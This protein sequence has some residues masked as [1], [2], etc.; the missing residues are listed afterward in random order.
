MQNPSLYNVIELMARESLH[1]CVQIWG[2][3]GTEQ[4]IKEL[5]S[6]PKMHSLRDYHLN[7]YNQVY[8][9][10]GKSNESN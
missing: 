9:Y 7:L 1:R 4:K 2:I 8:I 5:C 6:H 3:E 10:K